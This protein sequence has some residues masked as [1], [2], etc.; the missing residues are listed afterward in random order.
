MSPQNHN[1]EFELEI[2]QDCDS[3]VKYL[4]ALSEGFLKN[5]IVLGSKK[6]QVLFEPKGLIKFKVKARRRASEN[7]I[8]IKIAWEERVRRSPLP[9]T[10]IIEQQ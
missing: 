6:K 9:K 7:K 10:L 5:Q 4:N 1:G 2:L 8:V 3:I